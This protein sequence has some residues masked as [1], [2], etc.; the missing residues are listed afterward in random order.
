MSPAVLPT[1]RELR[2]RYVTEGRALPAELEAELRAD[3]RA[4]V[5]AIL[6]AVERRRR[7]NRAEGQRL[8]RMFR[9][10]RALRREGVVHLAGVDEVG[11]SPLA[12][13]VIS[14]AVVLPEDFRLVGVDDSKKLDAETRERLA[15]VIRREATCYA[16]G[17]VSPT[18]IDEI[19]I[20]RAG[21]LSMRRAL[22]GLS[23]QPEHVLVDARKLDEVKLPQTPIIH[24]DAKSFTI[25]AASIVAKVHRDA[26]MV[27]LD[28]QYP[29]YGL[30]K[31]KGY[32]VREH[33]DA[34][35]ELGVTPIHRRS[36]AP[37]RRALGIDPEQMDLF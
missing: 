7:K 26:L 5:Q 31:H 37:V 9:Y 35:M 20:Y 36:F 29:G 27:E 3:G 34:L 8:R 17:S 12:G 13:P 14:A 23:V 1:I 21:L 2:E 19:N 24:G 11:M 6:D 25:A 33:Q 18:E 4:G 15:A 16:I 10:E 22:E 28:E 30:A 32:P